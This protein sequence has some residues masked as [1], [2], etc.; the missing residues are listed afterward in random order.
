MKRGSDLPIGTVVYSVFTHERDHIRLL[1]S[2]TPSDYDLME[3]IYDPI[4]GLWATQWVREVWKKCS[5]LH[6]SCTL[7]EMLNKK[8]ISV[9]VQ[10]F[11]TYRELQQ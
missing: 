10:R 9:Q 2:T 4:D 8:L 3:Y 6:P 1:R 7:F 5:H 11:I